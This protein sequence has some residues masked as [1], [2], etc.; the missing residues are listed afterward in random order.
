MKKLQVFAS[1]FLGGVL[2]AVFSLAGLLLREEHPVAA[3]VLFGVML[4]AVLLLDLH[5]M[6]AKA[7]YLLWDSAMIR[8]RAVHLAIALCGNAVGA[9]AAGELLRR[10]YPRSDFAKEYMQGVFAGN[11]RHVIAGAVVCGMLMFVAVHAYRRARGGI[12]GAL[13]TLGAGAAIAFCGFEHSITDMFYVAY[14]RTYTGR[15]M[16]V[17]LLGIAGNLA[18]A[19]VTSLLYEY[20]KNTDEVNREQQEA[21]EA[22]ERRHHHHHHHSHETEE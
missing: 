5:L 9:F 20:K 13:V 19:I 1:S 2:V 6:T 14:G 10:A 15:A 12:V 17:L 3:S 18:G 16:A 7:G 11:V 4:L 21:E 8:T 22:S